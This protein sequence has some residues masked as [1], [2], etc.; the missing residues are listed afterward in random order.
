MLYRNPSQ[1]G[2]KK[3][4]FKL[5]KHQELTYVFLLKEE[6]PLVY[7]NFDCVTLSGVRLR[8]QNPPLNVKRK[9]N[10]ILTGE[11]FPNETT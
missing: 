3:S 10:E 11:Y 2:L 4:L 5:V 7:Y 8:D 9:F 1:A 6:L